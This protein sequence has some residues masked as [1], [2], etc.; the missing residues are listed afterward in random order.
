MITLALTSSGCFSLC[1]SSNERKLTKLNC[2]VKYENQTS[3]FHFLEIL[4]LPISFVFIIRDTPSCIISKYSN[5][6]L[7][8]LNFKKWRSLIA[9]YRHRPRLSEM[10]SWIKLCLLYREKLKRLK[11]SGHQK[12]LIEQRYFNYLSNSENQFY[13]PSPIPHIRVNNY[14]SFFI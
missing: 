9:M 6:F 8:S 2:C 3:F 5:L 14:S 12:E 7:Y 11:I 13:H 10:V 4:T 1:L